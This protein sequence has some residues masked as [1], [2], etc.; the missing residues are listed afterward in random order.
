M[1]ERPPLPAD[2]TPI[3]R[4]WMEYAEA[5]EARLAAC[6]EALREMDE[7]AARALRVTSAGVVGVVAAWYVRKI[8]R[9]ALAEGEG[10]DSKEG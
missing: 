10:N 5:L 7:T 1:T 9:Q 3:G 2:A 6:E 4:D 8:A